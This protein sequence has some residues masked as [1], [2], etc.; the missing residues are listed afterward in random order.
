MNSIE[1]DCSK[2]IGITMILK[3]YLSLVND[4]RIK[5]ILY[6]RYI[7]KN[8]YY[9]S[10]EHSLSLPLMQIITF[11]NTNDCIIEY[12]SLTSSTVDRT[13]SFSNRRN[14]ITEI[15]G[16]QLS[17]CKFCQRVQST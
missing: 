8:F 1:V 2:N 5:L 10:L 12:N 4:K 13:R 17:D 9:K 14:L 11:N 15:L 6:T 3:N 16:W 7:L